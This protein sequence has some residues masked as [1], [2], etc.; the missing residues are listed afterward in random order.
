M[1]RASSRCFLA[2][3]AVMRDGTILQRYVSEAVEAEGGR[4]D[5]S[6]V[7]LDRLDLSSS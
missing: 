4:I 5:R 3:T 6:Q 1:A 7:V 2:E